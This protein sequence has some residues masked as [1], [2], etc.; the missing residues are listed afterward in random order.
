[1]KARCL[2]MEWQFLVSLRGEGAAQLFLG[3]WQPVVLCELVN[4]KSLFWSDG[5]LSAGMGVVLT[6]R[7]GPLVECYLRRKALIFS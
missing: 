7:T 4:A 1:M 5:V 6:L 3:T 2:P